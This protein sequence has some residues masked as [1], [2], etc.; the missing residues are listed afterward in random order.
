MYI[1]ALQ[2][3]LALERIEQA[4]EMTHEVLSL[5]LLYN[6]CKLEIL[7]VTLFPY[8]QQI[9]ALETS[10]FLSGLNLYDQHRDMRLDIDNM[11]YEVGFA[12][13]FFLSWFDGCNLVLYSFSP[14][15]VSNYLIGIF[16]ISVLLEIS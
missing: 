15:A 3:L 16:S 14:S 2:V 1:F 11:S 6:A 13:F 12:L 9:L 8:P 7:L 10:L 4:E 5:C